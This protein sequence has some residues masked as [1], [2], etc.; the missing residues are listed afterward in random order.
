M[1]IY[2]YKWNVWKPYRSLKITDAV[3]T[4]VENLSPDI[5]NRLITPKQDDVD[6][7]ISAKRRRLSAGKESSEIYI[8]KLNSRLSSFSF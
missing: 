5:L 3:S 1:A 4:L 8:H 6:G 7:V 2:E